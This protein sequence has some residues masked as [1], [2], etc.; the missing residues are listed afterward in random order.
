M[1]NA[2]RLLYSFWKNTSILKLEL[3][4]RDDCIFYNNNRGYLTR[5]AYPVFCKFNLPSRR[6]KSL[7]I[8][9]LITK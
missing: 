1:E 4:E 7:S 2:W 8:N 5:I 9:L 3:D 6:F